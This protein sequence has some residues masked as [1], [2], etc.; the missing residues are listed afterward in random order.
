MSYS[1]WMY[2]RWYTFWCVASEDT[3]EDRDNA[4]FEI[5]TVARFPASALRE[6]M[7][8]CLNHVKQIVYESEE[9][10]PR[11]R[12]ME[13]LREYMQEFL[14]DVDEEYPAENE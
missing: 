12:E 6:D 10:M 14:K 4:I 8:A 3:I 2:S 9:R 1:R 7:D 5:C 11:P 13:E